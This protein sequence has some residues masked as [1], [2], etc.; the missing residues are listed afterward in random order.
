[1]N[2][3]LFIYSF[4]WK[5]VSILPRLAS[6]PGLSQA[7][8]LSLPSSQVYRHVPLHAASTV[9]LNFMVKL[10]YHWSRWKVEAGGDE[11]EHE[12]PTVL[13]KLSIS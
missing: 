12:G 13:C 1:M 10:D 6:N 4:I 9:V 7:S 11:E 5:E 3:L 2:V 8:C